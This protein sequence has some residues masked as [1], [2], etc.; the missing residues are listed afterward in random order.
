MLAPSLDY[1]TAIKLTQSG[2]SWGLAI[3]RFKKIHI[4]EK[5][6]TLTFDERLSLT[7][8]VLQSPGI[9]GLSA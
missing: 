6:Y 2:W 9:E 3:A 4:F 5:S 8:D 7:E 1:I